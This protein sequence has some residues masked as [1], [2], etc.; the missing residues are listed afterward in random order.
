[1]DTPGR[2]ALDRVALVVE[3]VDGERYVAVGLGGAGE[4]DVAH[5]GPCAVGEVDNVVAADTVTTVLRGVD[6]V[7]RFADGSAG[8][9]GD[10]CEAL[11]GEGGQARVE[12][13]A[14]GFL[15]VTF[16][17]GMVFGGAVVRTAGRG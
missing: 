17:C 15:I 2:A 5:F 1:M 10:Q 11:R 3:V 12:V 8:G 7:P 9:G 6:V 4:P 14:H 16:G 13:E